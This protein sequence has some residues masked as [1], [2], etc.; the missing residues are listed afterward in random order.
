MEQTGIEGLQKGKPKGDRFAGAA[1]DFDAAKQRGKNED[2]SMAGAEL[3]LE[4]E[5]PPALE[6]QEIAKEL[7]EPSGRVSASETA[8]EEYQAKHP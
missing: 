3:I 5:R 4:G 7:S 8:T 6:K 2:G 1:K